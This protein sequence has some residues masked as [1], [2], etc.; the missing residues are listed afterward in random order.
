MEM[1]KKNVAIIVLAVVLVASGIGN[2]LLFMNV[3]APEVT[4]YS[5]FLLGTGNGPAVIDPIDSWDSA[6][7]D[8]IAQVAECLFWYDLTD[9]ALP[10][11]GLLAESYNWTTP[12]TIEI[13]IR[14]PAHGY[15]YFH[16]GSKLDADVVKWNLDRINYFINATGTLA[17]PTIPAFPA[18]IYF[19]PDGRSIMNKTE[20]LSEFVVKVTLNDVFAS[21]VPLMSYTGSAMISMESHS[22]TEYIDLTTGK[23]IGTGPYMYDYYRTDVEVRFTRFD[24]Y[25]DVSGF[26][27]KVVFVVIDDTATRNQAMLGH[28]VDMIFGADPDLLDQFAADPL[29]TV[30]ELGTDLIYWYLAFDCWKVPTAWREAISKAINYTYIIMEIRNGNALRGPPAVPAG[31]PGHDDTV[32]V[33]QYDIPEARYVMQNLS[34]GVGWECGSQVGDVFTPGNDEALWLAATF[35]ENEFGHQI[36]MNYHAGS[37]FNRDLNDLIVYDLNFIGIVPVETTRE[38]SVFLDDGEQGLLK[39]MWY[40]GWGPDYIDAFN[41]L[42]PLFNPASASNFINLTD[43]DIINW[44]ADAAAETNTTARYA[45]FSDIQHRLFEVLYA[46]TP[47]MASLGRAVHGIDI[48]DY[49]YNQMGNLI[50]WPIWRDTA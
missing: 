37:S 22:A 28:T 33:A 3:P 44:L 4:D 39:G 31:M 13:T 35:F 26:F 17:P 14:Q 6:S 18:S 19:L 41:M 9:P 24:R 29:T 16:D 20:V 7:N 36:D 47:L 43:T 2:I 21:F 32:V 30:V 12:T 15:I 46:H 40:V 23:L 1:E 48:M 11:E 25:W 49:P 34:Y 8:V 38:W 42:D 50:L 5:T 27:E 10:L 45:I